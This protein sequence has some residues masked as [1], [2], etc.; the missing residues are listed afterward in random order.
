MLAC[1]LVGGVQNTTDVVQDVEAE[2]PLDPESSLYQWSESKTLYKQ[3]NS[4]WG[5]KMMKNNTIWEEGCLI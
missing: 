2:L 5:D 3:C 1:T 4:T